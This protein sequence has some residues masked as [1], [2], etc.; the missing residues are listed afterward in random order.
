[1]S[2]IKANYRP[3][4]R[5]VFHKTASVLDGLSGKVIGISA[6][7]AEMTF[8]IV[9]LDLPLKDFKWSAIVMTEHCL[10]EAW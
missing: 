8:Y 4:D 2:L 3:N 6:D 5:V 9:K 7:F 1:M 10:K